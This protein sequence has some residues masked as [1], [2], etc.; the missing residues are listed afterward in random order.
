MSADRH[1][2][3]TLV[4]PGLL[5][6]LGVAGANPLEA[7]RRLCEGLELPA[8]ERYLSRATRSADT[9]SAG[10]LAA[11]LFDCFG[12]SGQLPDWPVAAVTRRADGGAEDGR[13]WLRA[14]PVH[15]RASMGDLS[16]LDG[17]HLVIG[18][19]EA[20]TLATEINTELDDPDFRLEALAPARWYLGRDRAPRL[21]TLPP[22]EL[23][24]EAIGEHLPRGEDAPWWRAR[25]NEVQMILHASPVNRARAARGEPAINS[26]WLWGGGVTPQVPA[27]SWQSVCCD[28]ILVVGLADLAGAASAALPVDAAAWLAA[29]ASPGNHLLVWTAAYEAARRFD[30]D[31]WRSFVARFE[32]GWMTPL[33]DA[34]ARGS[35]QSLRLRCAAGGDFLLGRG[36]L[37]RRWW[38]RS[39]AFAR[40]MSERRPGGAQHR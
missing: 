16:L 12:V 5:G 1:R 27:G 23:G 3:L 17:A 21:Q 19:D 36:A 37:R 15:L 9:P 18:S 10:G 26:L 7:A 34:L 30:V 29:A 31:A 28:E 22:W 14:D 13:W 2:F 11:L 40:I 6:P 25:A 39:R 4:V 33:L 32:S 35:V 8:L 20:E 38:R 24:G